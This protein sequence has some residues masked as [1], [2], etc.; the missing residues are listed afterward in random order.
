[1][2]LVPRHDR[3]F[4]VDQFVDR[5]R[6][7]LKQIPGAR[8]DI[9]VTGNIG[10][11]KPINL[12]LRG[13]DPDALARA[14]DAV[15][16]GMR[17][18]DTVQD[19]TSSSENLTPEVHITPKVER[20]T[21]MGVSV[22]AIA[23]A[24]RLATQGENSLNLPKFNAGTQQIDILVELNRKYK[25]DLSALRNLTVQGASGLVPLQEVADIE[26]G[27]G[28]VSIQR[29]DRERQLTITANTTGGDLGKAMSTIMAL[30]A[31]KNLPAGVS[32]DTS[33]QSKFIAEIFAA[34]GS[35]LAAGVMFI[36]IVLVL[37]FSS[38][39]QPITI[40]MAL[41]MSFAG[42]FLGLLMFH[43]DLGMMALIGIVMLMGLVSKNSILLVD[44]AI[45]A[46]KK[47]TPRREALLHSGHDR[48]RP[49]L[50]TTIAMIAGMLPIALS[51]GE[52]TERMSPMAC[53]VIGGLLTSTLLTLM[54]V[55]S[56]FTVVDDAQNWVK[57]LFRRGKKGAPAVEP[58]SEPTP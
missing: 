31:V 53:A 57:G 12:I 56:V 7:L 37:L 41:P 55:P 52:G 40:M 25:T 23:N 18:L 36:Y 46:R 45:E 30:P 2:Y 51:F 32:T 15:M 14:N 44:Y 3:K 10:S 6:P 9:Y 16:A 11:A 47:G 28:P 1:V 39:T 20:A 13:D 5:V 43:K 38:F 22:Q 33:G 8:V 35:A 17:T 48:V 34:F 29:Y 21:Q 24:V 54:V 26:L 42:A 58:P 4:S 27:S 50:M 19:G 49:I